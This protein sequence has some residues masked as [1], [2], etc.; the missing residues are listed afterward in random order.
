MGPI[1]RHIMAL[2]LGACFSG[3]ATRG[4][5]GSGLDVLAV[6]AAE[7]SAV[8]EV[9][10]SSNNVIPMQQTLRG[11]YIFTIFSLRGIIVPTYPTI[12][13]IEMPFMPSG[14]QMRQYGLTKSAAILCHKFLPEQAL[15]TVDYKKQDQCVRFWRSV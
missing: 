15:E 8:N 14:N 9:A 5:A 10:T 13:C 6:W 11:R 7:F 2:V 4:M 1:K 12:G 3:A